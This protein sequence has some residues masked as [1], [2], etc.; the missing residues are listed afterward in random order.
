MNS[1]FQMKKSNRNDELVKLLYES[2]TLR[3]SPEERRQQ[4]ISNLMSLA[5]NPASEAER[6]YAE[7]IVDGKYP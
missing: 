4:R 6:K 2:A 7:D 1:Q 5:D 3:L